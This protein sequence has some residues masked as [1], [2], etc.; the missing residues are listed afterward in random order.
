LLAKGSLEGACS[1][2]MKIQE[3]ASLMPLPLYL[4]SISIP[5]KIYRN[6]FLHTEGDVRFEIVS[7]YSEFASTEQYHM[8]TNTGSITTEESNIYVVLR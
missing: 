7:A 4:Q 6:I 1:L 8:I 5:F 3:F 2:M